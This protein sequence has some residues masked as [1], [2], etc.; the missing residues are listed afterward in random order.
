MSLDIRLPMGV[1]F[2]IL[3]LILTIAGLFTSPATLHQS[4]DVNLN[5]WWGLVILLFGAAMLLLSLLGRRRVGKPSEHRTN[6][7]SHHADRVGH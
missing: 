6:S 2:A 1:M 7:S 5:L 4:L 3:G